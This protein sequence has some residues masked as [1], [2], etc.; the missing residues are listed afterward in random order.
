MKN[1]EKA[2][3]ADDS[4]IDDNE[5]QEN[6]DNEFLEENEDV[7]EQEEEIHEEFPE[8]SKVDTGPLHSLSELPINLTVEIAC[9]KISLDKLKKLQ[10]GNFLE[11]PVSLKDN[12]N[13]TVNG[14]KIGKGELIKLG[15]VLGVKVLEI[16]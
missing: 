14:E 8:E 13:L 1:N 5:M 3:L 7:H 12:V 11:L 16:G 6:D 15:E 10:P 4:S 9:F 2:P